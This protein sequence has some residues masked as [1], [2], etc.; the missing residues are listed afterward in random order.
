MRRLSVAA[1]L[2]LSVAG[3]A[4]ASPSIEGAWQGALAAGPGVTL[5]LVVHFNRSDEKWTATLDSVDQNAFGMPVD[6]VTAFR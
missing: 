5:R 6:E 2:L 4:A 1:I 3:L